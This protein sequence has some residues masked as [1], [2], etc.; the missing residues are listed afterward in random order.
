ME[1]QVNTSAANAT[2]KYRKPMRR[3]KD[4][5][6]IMV[7]F[8]IAAIILM[9]M[10]FV[11]L[12]NGVLEPLKEEDT[13][14]FEATV[15]TMDIGRGT[16]YI[17]F[18]EYD[19]RVRVFSGFVRDMPNRLNSL[20]QGDKIY[21]RVQS[22]SDRNTPD[23]PPENYSSFYQ[24]VA[25]RTD[26]KEILTL[27]DYS[28]YNRA[29]FTLLTVEISIFSAALLVVAIVNTVLWRKSIKFHKLLKAT[30]PPELPPKEVVTE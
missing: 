3:P 18:E 12:M 4:Y 8:Y 20:V 27:E 22:S 10:M 25:V 13:V 14:E 23:F 30:P 24:A 29:G 6:A 19:F 9:I 1:N 28:K 5:V 2:P 17:Y 7:I 26:S 21:I 16:S 15:K 11:P